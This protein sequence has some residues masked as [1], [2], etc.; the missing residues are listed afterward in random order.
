MKKVVAVVAAL[1]SAQA[2]QAQIYACQSIDATGF[3]WKG[4]TWTRTNF[5]GQK[6]FFL[7]VENGLI[8]K[9]S[10]AAPLNGTVSR[11]TCTREAVASPVVL[12][13]SDYATIISFS[14]DT[15]NGA[16]AKVFGATQATGDTR[17]DTVSTDMFTCQRM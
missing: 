11:I 16:V 13:C 3:A 15:G 14:P 4:S 12:A 6:P 7:R 5:Q 10:A 2:A 8:T 1:L 17:K 9:E